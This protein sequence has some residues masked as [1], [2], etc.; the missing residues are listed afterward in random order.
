MS[1]LAVILVVLIQLGLFRFSKFL[2]IALSWFSFSFLWRIAS[3]AYLASHES[4]WA[5]EISKTLY[6]TA[7]ALVSFLL[8]VS[9]FYASFFFVFSPKRHSKYIS[10][11]K[12]HEN[13]N[14][15]DQTWLNLMRVASAIV[16]IGYILFILACF[17][18]GPS[19]DSYPL[20]SG[21]HRR[22]F[23]LQMSSSFLYQTFFRTAS[24]SAVGLGV[25][26]VQNLLFLKSRQIWSWLPGIAWATSIGFY[27]LLGHRFSAQLESSYFF[28]LPVSLVFIGDRLKF[29]QAVTL[30]SIV[31]LA[32]LVFVLFSISIFFS[33]NVQ[34]TL[35]TIKERVLIDQAQLWVKSV[36]DLYVY[37]ENTGDEARAVV[38]DS[39]HT[40]LIHNRPAQYLM[41]K[42]M[43][44]D[45][46]NE[47]WNQNH[48]ITIG[49][50]ENIIH[51]TGQFYVFPVTL[52]LGLFLAWLMNEVF[53]AI[54]RLE[55]SI[56]CVFIVLM[57]PVIAIFMGGSPHSFF[58]TQYLLKIIFGGVV[59]MGTRLISDFIVESRRL[60]SNRLG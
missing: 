18:S 54:L 37:N 14:S 33:G 53:K 60:S 41:F 35:Q 30:K 59:I 32:S 27:F 40:E 52:I 4:I 29:A 23:N 38:F 26:Q 55:P 45:S 57:N 22:D 43:G 42:E 17:L 56:A 36:S 20:F 49:F 13:G 3:I 5:R 46:A 24:Y 48:M 50:P 2:F 31:F 28:L 25:L 10:L 16:S 15:V 44:S 39:P 12:I 9:I 1:Y 19:P 34:N 6:P 8:I 58:S 47:S 7:S 11:T 51:L 21:I